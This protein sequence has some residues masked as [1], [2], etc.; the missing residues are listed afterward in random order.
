[1]SDNTVGSDLAGTLYGGYTPLPQIDYRNDPSHGQSGFDGSRYDYDQPIDGVPVAPQPDA[2]IR[3]YDTD[4]KLYNIMDPREAPHDPHHYYP[5]S[6]GWS[7]DIGA[8]LAWERRGDLRSPDPGG[9]S[10]TD[11]AGFPLSPQRSSP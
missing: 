4:D 2:A 8:A 10:G 9:Q 3:S 7:P 11:G 5:R 6:P 1:M